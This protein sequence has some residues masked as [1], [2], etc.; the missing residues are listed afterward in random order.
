[1]MHIYPSI[2]ECGY[3]KNLF[4]LALDNFQSGFNIL[5]QQNMKDSSAEFLLEIGK[6]YF[7]HG[8]YSQAKTYYNQAFEII[9][10]YNNI[11]LLN[12]YY[13]YNADIFSAQKQFDS[14]SLYLDK[15]YFEIRL[16]KNAYLIAQS[17][18]KISEIYLSK[19]QTIEA[20]S[21]L[22]EAL[23]TLLNSD[24]QSYEHNLLLIEIYIQTGKVFQLQKLYID[25]MKNYNLAKDASQAYTSNNHL[26]Y[27]SLYLIANLRYEDNKIKEAESIAHDVLVFCNL[28]NDLV[29]KKD[30]YSLLSNIYL[31]KINFS[32]ALKYKQL[33]VDITDSIADNKLSSKFAEIK[34]AVEVSDKE[35]QLQIQEK[36]IESQKTHNFLLTAILVLSTFFIVGIAFSYR[37]QKRTNKELEKKNIMIEEQQKELQR[38]NDTKDK[39]FSILAHNL[40]NPFNSLINLS[41]AQL[42]EMKGKDLPELENYAKIIND[43]AKKGHLL[44]ENLLLWSQSQTGEIKYNPS[45]VDITKIIKNK[46][47]QHQ[48]EI[49]NRG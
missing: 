13:I 47:N 43:S 32:E 48:V 27:E 20:L 22:N 46:I 39:F 18:K 19:N 40:R 23:N 17:F 28:N 16:T 8:L 31:R 6:V 3:N 12:E 30:I 2:T 10:K 49:V 26:F 15:A 29:L 4:Y 45:E 25:A 7:R 5:R 38:L 41:S 34:A 37:A 21:Y 24:E 35:Y 44:L 42:K 1:M 14:A 33:L 36:T 9:S 11:Y